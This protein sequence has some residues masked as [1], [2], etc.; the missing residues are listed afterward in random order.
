MLSSQLHAISNVCFCH[1][2]KGLEMK[3]NVKVKQ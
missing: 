1:K 3:L 2:K